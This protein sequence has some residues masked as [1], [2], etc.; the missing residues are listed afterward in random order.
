MQGGKY[1][2]LFIAIS[3]YMPPPAQRHWFSQ[4]PFG[5]IPSIIGCWVCGGL[6]PLPLSHGM[7][8]HNGSCK[9]HTFC[10]RHSKFPPLI[11][12]LPEKLKERNSLNPS[13]APVQWLGIACWSFANNQP[14]SSEFFF[15]F[16]LSNPI[17][18]GFWLQPRSF[19]QRKIVSPCA[20]EQ[21]LSVNICLEPYL[22]LVVEKKQS[23]G[24][25]LIIGF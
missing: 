14:L 12:P 4:G 3:D 9:F 11:S 22:W 19:Q 20:P 25:T 8:Y 16:E 18:E 15:T 5:C 7:L 21:E 6:I 23:T 10:G 17:L 24:V 13:G 2:S 1:K